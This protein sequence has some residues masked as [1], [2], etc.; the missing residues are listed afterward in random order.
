MK[1]VLLLTWLLSSGAFAQGVES[2]D[3][4]FAN[5]SNNISL[6][7]P[8]QV[9]QGITGA[10]NFTFGFNEDSAQYF[11][12]L[13]ALPGKDS[14]LLVLTKDDQI[15]S[16]I[17]KYKENLSKLNYFIDKEESIGN[18]VPL[19]NS[20]PALRMKEVMTELNTAS[21]S[22]AR[23]TA[24][25]DKLSAF[26][27]RT[28]KGNMK[29]KR[30]NALKLRVKDVIY[31]RNE[32][33]MIFEL[34]NKSRIDFQLNYLNVYLSQGNRKRNASFQRLLKAPVHIFEVP[35]VVKHKQKKRFLYVLPKFTIGD[36]ENIEVEVREK[37]GSRSLIARLQGLH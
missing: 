26:Y 2:L 9:R 32:T 12:L 4:I 1:N 25:L 36:H 18:E 37:R 3:T 13:K 33:F 16:Y 30:K 22:M 34:E 24:Y 11:G 23:R 7:F 6:F 28:S 29:T 5:E 35:E 8:S 31:H 19:E 10:P 14:N 17:L 20:D 27:L 21:D 15:Y